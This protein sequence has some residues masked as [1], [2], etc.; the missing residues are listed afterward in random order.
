MMEQEDVICESD[1]WVLIDLA[2]VELVVLDA[3]DELKNVKVNS[4]RTPYPAQKSTHTLYRLQ[5]AS[6]GSYRLIW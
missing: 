5:I 2:N 4:E 3:T 1:V 6:E